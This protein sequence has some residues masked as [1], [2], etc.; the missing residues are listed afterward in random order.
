LNRLLTW[1]GRLT[2]GI[3]VAV[4]LSGVARANGIIDPVMRVLEDDFSNAIVQGT[5]FFPNGTGGGVFGFFN[6]S[7]QNITELAFQAIIAPGL[8]PAIITSAFNCNQGNFNPFFQYCSVGYLPTSGELTISFWGTDPVT[9][10]A[11]LHQ[12]V[13]ALPAGC[14]ATPDAVGCTSS[15]HFAISLADTFDIHAAD[16]SGGWSFDKNPILFSAGGPTFTVTELQNTFG[17]IPSTVPEPGTVGGIGA[18]L[19]VL[20]AVNA[21]RRR[22]AADPDPESRS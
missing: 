22:R 1:V 3:T 4:G 13:P 11:Q 19:A 18:G 5:N 9:N 21:R 12:G 2:V 15:G 20:M 7:N 8:T 16:L 6:S 14:L 10:P 17:A